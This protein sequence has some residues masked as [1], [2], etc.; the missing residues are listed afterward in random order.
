MEFRRD[1]A[2]VRG[3]RIF[4]FLLGA[5]LVA[6]PAAA[7]GPDVDAAARDKKAGAQQTFDAGSRLYDS[8]RYREALTAFRASHDIVASPN[9]HLMAARCLRGMDQNAEAYREFDA[10]ALEARERGNSY[11]Q[12]A[13]TAE[14]E[15]DD[16]KQKVALV[17]LRLADSK[18]GVQVKR[19]EQVLPAESVGTVLVLNPGEEVFSASAPDGSTAK[20]SVS[21]AAGS[22]QDIELRLET[23]A[24]PPEEA[25]PPPPPPREPVAPPPAGNTSLRT[26]A[27]VAGGVGVVGLGAFAAFGAMS[28]SKLHTLESSCPGHECPPAR[29]DD[30]DSGKQFR[31][32]ANVG[33]S[34]G[35]VGLGAGVTLFVIGSSSSSSTESKHVSLVIGPTSVNVLGRM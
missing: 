13:K 17:T 30:I 18:E 4:P 27:L 3:G 9:S 15:R 6:A 25:P 1:R 20:V 11:E 28:Q 31:L 23:P 22:S 7:R 19:G 8:K 34:L 29:Q 24:S 16:L 21:L 33:L 5:L 2:V 10:V 32:L 26:W 14:T 12:T 35:V